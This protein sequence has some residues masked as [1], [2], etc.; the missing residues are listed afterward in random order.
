MEALRKVLQ[1]RKQQ[2]LS[3][4][5]VIGVG[6]G[7]KF[8]RGENTGRKAIVVIV[9]KKLP[10]EEI[11]RGHVVPLSLDGFEVDVI[12]TG[13]FYFLARTDRFRPAQ[14]GI[15]IG[16]YAVTAGTFGAVVKDNLS[17]QRV[18]LSNNHVLANATSGSD[19]RAE[20]GD[21]V[22]QPGL[23]D[24][25]KL[26]ADQIGELLRFVPINFTL[27]ES[28][29]AIAQK[30]AQAATCALKLFKKDY[31][32]SF[33]KEAQEENVVDCAIAVPNRDNLITSQVLELGE[34]TGFAEAEIGQL[35]RKSGRTSGMTQGR[36][37][38]T[39][40][41]IRVNMTTGR[42]ALFTDQIMSDLLS[43][44]GDSGSI[45]LDEKNRAVGLLFAGSD[46]MTLCNRFSN[47][48]RLLNI[49]I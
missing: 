20:V 39:E 22:L 15:S 38:A 40:V 36:V 30:T 48:M 18:I 7:D 17:G 32:V 13:R 11:K 45:V 37:R 14:P 12:E 6:A 47:V 27:A 1:S 49:S 43:K 31:R 42:Q 24:N 33:L 34:I 8:V 28:Q 19:G 2:L 21:P 25:G 16:H 3:L 23:M 46:N 41:T 4:D 10:K 44:P 9:E 35:V 5:N 29:C 26:A